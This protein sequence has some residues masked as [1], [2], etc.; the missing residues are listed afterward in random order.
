MQLAAKVI[1]AQPSLK[2]G[3]MNFRQP[4][5]TCRKMPYPGIHL[6]R[7]AYSDRRSDAM[8]AAC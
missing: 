4:V 5:F 2:K 7:T 6:C 1:S 8:P 3:H